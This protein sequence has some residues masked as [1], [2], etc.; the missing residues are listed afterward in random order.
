MDTSCVPLRLRSS[1]SLLAGPT[2][3]GAYVERAAVWGLPALA[4]TDRDALYGAIPFYDAAR[5]RGVRPILGSEITEPSGAAPPTVAIALDLA[6]YRNLCQLVTRRRIGAW[7]PGEEGER[8]P[9]GPVARAPRPV[10]A[11][12]ASPSPSDDGARCALRAGRGLPLAPPT[13]LKSSPWLPHAIADAH[14]GLFFLSESPALL[15]A[16]ADAG[17]PRDRL[18]VEI[19]RPGRARR[20]ERARIDA[21]RHAGIAIVA[22]TDVWFAD[23][24]DHATH[25]ALVAARENATV[26]TLPPGA[27]A[28][29]ERRLRSPAETAA[30][31]A[32]LPRALDGARAAV[33][34]AR[35]A[36]PL[37]KPIL[38]RT[39]L[40]PGETAFSHVFRLA[41]EGIARRYPGGARPAVVSRLARELDVVARL[42]L[43]DYFLIVA[44]ICQFARA[45][46]IPMVGRG[47]GAS[48]L[49]AYLLGV[50]SV[51]PLE[52]DLYFERFLHESREDLPDLDIDLSWRDRDRVIAHVYRTYGDDKVAMIA[53]HVLFQPRSAFREAARAL[54][55]PPTEIDAL[56]RLVPHDA[57]EGIARA[58]LA[59]PRARARG[60]DPRE[61]RLARIVA[62][63]DRL[64][65]LPRHLGI[66]PG[67]LVIADGALDRYVPLEEAAKG[68]VVTQYEMRAIERIG[69]VKM[70]LLGNRALS[71]LAEAREWVARREEDRGAAGPVAREI[72]NGSVSAAGQAPGGWREGESRG[73]AGGARGSPCPARSESPTR[74]DDAADFASRARTGRG[75]RATGPAG[76]DLDAVANDDPDAARILREARTLGCFQVESPGMRQLLVEIGTHDLRGTID[77]LSLIRPGAAASGA[78]ER[79]VRRARGLEPTTHLHP[80]LA[81]ILGRT[82]GLLIYEEDVMAVAAAIGGL[83]LEDADS[84][85]RAIGGVDDPEERRALANGF[86]RSA[87]LS[88]VEPDAARAVWEALA[89]FSAYAFSRAHAAGYGVIAHRMAWMKARWPAAFAVA[90]LNNGAGMYPRWAHVE[91]AKR[92]GVAILP[93]CVNRSGAE[94]T[95]EWDGGAAGAVDAPAARVGL[96]DVRGLSARTIGRA[97]A[98]RGER[99][100]AGVGDFRRRTGAAL[101]EAEALVLAGAFA[102][103]G[104]TRPTLLWELHARD[105]RRGAGGSARRGGEALAGERGDARARGPMPELAVAAA[106]EDPPGPDLPELPALERLRNEAEILG[107]TV[108]GHPLDLF[109]DALRAMRAGGA[110]GGW[111]EPETSTGAERARRGRGGGRESD[112]RERAP[113]EVASDRTRP[114]RVVGVAAASRRTTTRSREEMLF[115]TL[116]DGADL[117]ECVLFPAAYRRAA[118][119]LGAFGPYLAEG[120]LD[121]PLG[122]PTLRVERLRLLA[123]A[124]ACPRALAEARAAGTAL[125]AFA[126]DADALARAPSEEEGG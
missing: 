11:R 85:R 44:E 115:L 4:L 125:P 28:S 79:F 99:P 65:G 105:P 81:R 1:G 59:S 119:I 21:A 60:V 6:G 15:E 36:L 75:T 14:E 104:R 53:T 37:G 108:S 22:S 66:H 33:D 39:P 73:P 42:G 27:L 41:S 54:G 32:D 111:R 103:T 92:M 112:A 67:G 20:D 98:A 101:R 84:L 13:G 55:V 96:G 90:F 100:F 114:A 113:G 47:S 116:D 25:Q 16:L 70:D 120:V 29:P 3:A 122:A 9:V 95:V 58:L 97:V 35:L 26:A 117:V 91:D 68:I 24:E 86:V 50:T 87:V 12:E 124:G 107:F 8:G 109:A 49:I 5:A 118:G 61:P 106:P 110:R 77:A 80:R 10:L 69:L 19:V 31:F 64:V 18:G 83:S 93:P 89:R 23:A 82:H 123:A 38:P 63:A 48:S 17:V 56:G 88:G 94:W 74:S 62:I 43:L 121:A 71:V 76:P 51:D 2:P 78:K 30:L 46:A 52:H 57:P 45:E 34:R 102:F 40:P 72:L 7:P 126:G